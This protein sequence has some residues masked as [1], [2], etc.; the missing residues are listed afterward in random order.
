MRFDCPRKEFSDA[1]NMAAS[2]SSTRTSIPIY[3]NLKVEATDSLVRVLGCDGELWIERS[4]P[5]MV[6]EPGSVCL[7][8]KTLSDIVNSLADGDVELKTLDASGALLTQSGSE[9]RLQTLDP[10]DFPEPPAFGGEGDLTLP[11]KQLR[12]AIDSV[13]YAVS[14][15]PHRG[16]ITGVLFSYT[17]NKL[18]LVA[19]DAHRLAVR[20]IEHSGNG[21]S[22]TAVVPEKALKAI[23]TVPLGD[24][25][26]ATLRFGNGR[27][28]IEAAGAR[29]I[30][31][32]LSGQF[33]NWERVVPSETTRTWSVEVD[34]LSEKVKRAMI[35][36]RDNA[37]RIRF[38]GDGDQI[39]ISARSEEK[40][41]AKEEVPMV[42][43][44]GN[45]EIAFNGK[46]V[47]DAL[48]AIPGTGV[49][50]EMTESTRP[51]IFRPADDLEGYYCVIMPMQLS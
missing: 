11:M 21:T 50:I 10:A 22:L 17:G 45:L 9:Y 26:A 1:V 3:Q 43:N 39:L 20:E 41:E 23:K 24:D 51:A 47:Q 15:D 19:T 28:G 18:L 25:D 7:Q 38:K 2:A 40:G 5:A 13:I 14:T 4:F 44:G 27:L 16:A 6:S 29:V 12:S 48:T 42:A 34:Q 37:N 49:Q 46:Y 32:L 33:P 31:N 30:S 36:A 35:L 8:A